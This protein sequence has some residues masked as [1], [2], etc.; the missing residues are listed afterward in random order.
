MSATGAGGTAEFDHAVVI[1]RDRLNEVAPQFERAGFTLSEVET[2]NVG[3]HNRL[4]VLADCYLELLGWPQ[5]APPARAEIA[6]SP[7]GLEA[8]VFRSHDAAATYDRLRDGGWAV[9]PVLTLIRPAAV[10]GN[11]IEA[12]FD[13]VRFAEQPLAGFRMYFCQHLTPACV[14][15]PRLME[16]S[17][18]ARRLSRI[19]AVA[20]DPASTAA[21]IA[22]V[23]GATAR[24]VGSGWE[25]TLDNTS[26]TVSA[27]PDDV[28]PRLSGVTID[29][30]GGRPLTLD[31]TADSLTT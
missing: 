20:P 10:D 5:G 23:A 16:H 25:V 29:T 14:W 21:T 8:L 13:T 17:N 1:V 4:I 6:D 7:L 2:H 3:S 11:Q 9:N 19:D 24:P 26:I 27:S 31:L 28:A 12:R 18:G 22:A 15:Q 30:I